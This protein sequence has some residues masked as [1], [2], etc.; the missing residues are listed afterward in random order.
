M[1]T[2]A[3]RKIQLARLQEDAFKEQHDLN[4]K[5]MKEESEARIAREERLTKLQE[6]WT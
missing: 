2:W 1:S 6:K 5:L 3:S 4:L